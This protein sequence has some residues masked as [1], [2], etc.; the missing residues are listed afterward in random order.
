MQRTL[1]ERFI[2]RVTAILVKKFPSSKI[3]VTVSVYDEN[4]IEKNGVIATGKTLWVPSNMSIFE[5]MG[6]LDNIKEQVLSQQVHKVTS[7]TLPAPG[8]LKN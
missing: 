6:H 7:P 4:K 5:V 2:L 3:L 1:L 8:N